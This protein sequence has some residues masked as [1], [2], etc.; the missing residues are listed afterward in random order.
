MRTKQPPRPATF[1]ARYKAALKALDRQGLCPIGLGLRKE[2]WEGCHK[3][4]DRCTLK[5]ARP[6][7]DRLFTEEAQK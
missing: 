7:F 6:C 5:D 2:G 1:S 3:E 4:D